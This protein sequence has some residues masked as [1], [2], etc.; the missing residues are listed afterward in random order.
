MALEER[1]D[2]R[3]LV[4]GLKNSTLWLAYEEKEENRELRLDL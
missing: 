1:E 4:L 3:E 2:V